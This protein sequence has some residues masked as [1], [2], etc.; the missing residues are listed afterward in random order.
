M[1]RS[2]H[3]G[4]DDRMK[5]VPVTETD[6]PR[7]EKHF[8]DAAPADSIM[9]IQSPEGQIQVATDTSSPLTNSSGVQNAVW[10]GLMSAGALKK[11]VRGVV[12]WGRCRDLAEL[13]QS[14]IPAS[15][16]CLDKVMHLA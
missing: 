5:L 13:R 16:P 12:I 10:G 15:P 8:V 3:Q 4:L 14:A 7:P 11:G 1:V 9:V 2:A 6:A